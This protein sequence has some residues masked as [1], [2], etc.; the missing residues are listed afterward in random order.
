[1]LSSSLRDL[2]FKGSNQSKREFCRAVAIGS[3]FLLN[4]CNAAIVAIDVA[5]H[6]HRLGDDRIAVIAYIREV[7]RACASIK[8]AVVDDFK[9]IGI[10]VN[11]IGALPW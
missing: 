9:T 4:I 7:L 2:G 10:L 11:C 1:M 8:R 6:L 3:K 5:K